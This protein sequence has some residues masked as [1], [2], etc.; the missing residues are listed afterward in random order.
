MFHR[1]VS[2]WPLRIIR[3]FAPSV[4]GQSFVLGG[5]QRNH[6][7]AALAHQRR[8]G[9]KL[10][11]LDLRERDRL[12]DRF[13]SLDFDGWILGVGNVDGE[14]RGGT[15]S[16]LLVP[17]VIDDEAGARLHLAEI[18]Q[19]NGI[20]HAIPDGGFVA[21][22]ISERVCRRFGLEQIIRGHG[23]FTFSNFK[24][25]SGYSTRGVDGGSTPSLEQQSKGNSSTS[26]L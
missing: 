2:P 14:N 13:A 19:G 21:L 17:G 22:Q 4:A 6:G 8:V 20:V 16:C 3:A 1:N 9:E 18:P 25:M 26:L 7:E 24:E 10:I 15:D 12:G 23:I 11:G 5:G